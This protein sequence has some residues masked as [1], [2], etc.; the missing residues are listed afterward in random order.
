[1]AEGLLAADAA[2]FNIVLTVHDELLTIERQDDPVHTPHIL[3]AL[4]SSCPSWAPG[5]LL[6]AE[7][8]AAQRYRK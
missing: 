1:M 3:G 2:G 7:S 5:L 6:G 8:Y 4:L